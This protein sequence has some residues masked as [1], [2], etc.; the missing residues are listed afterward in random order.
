M[1]E[2]IKSVRC[3]IRLLPEEKDKWKHFAKLHN[4]TVSELITESV[5]YFLNKGDKNEYKEDLH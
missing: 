2:K 3:E 5:N 4:M 1:K